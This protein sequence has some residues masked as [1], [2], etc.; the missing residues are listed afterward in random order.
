M[1]MGD[2]EEFRIQRASVAA[3]LFAM[4]FVLMLA[5][6]LVRL[7]WTLAA[8]LIAQLRDQKGR[9]RNDTIPATRP[10]SIGGS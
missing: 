7:V 6:V 9:R 2:I 5:I 10:R 4:P 8:V 1:S 3:L